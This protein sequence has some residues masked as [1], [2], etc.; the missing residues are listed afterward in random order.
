MQLF[1]QNQPQQEPNFFKLSDKI[2][3]IE[4]KELEKNPE[5]QNFIKNS[6][7]T[8]FE[9]FYKNG[10]KEFFYS[11]PI[12]K[13]KLDLE[14]PGSYEDSPHLFPPLI[15]L[16]INPKNF[17][18]EEI[19]KTLFHEFCHHLI[20]NKQKPLQPHTNIEK[21]LFLDENS[22]RWRSIEEGLANIFARF[23]LKKLSNENSFKSLD[24]DYTQ[25]E[26]N[27]EAS[28]PIEQSI[29]LIFLASLDLKIEDLVNLYLK[30]SSISFMLKEKFC[31]KYQISEEEFF[32]L[33]PDPKPLLNFLLSQNFNINDLEQK[34][35]S[36][37]LK[38]D[39]LNFLINNYKELRDGIN[40]Y[41]NMEKDKQILILKTLYSELQKK[42][43]ED[44]LFYQKQENQSKL[45]EATFLI[46]SLLGLD[47]YIQI[48]QVKV[49][50]LNKITNEEEGIINPNF[51][52]FDQPE[53]FKFLSF[54]IHPSKIEHLK[55]DIDN[56][57]K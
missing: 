45:K 16:K 36:L 25:I 43:Q 3:K 54:I 46:A 51:Y 34:I 41:K 56:L 48:E 32:T 31:Q 49:Y 52:I 30:D 26:K 12:L 37:G 9:F 33:L 14:V 57:F 15:S 24:L 53:E 18:K 23:Y 21:H 13:L 28:Y 17:Q 6:T 4:S 7:A 42:A 19:F 40:K 38:Q 1:N 55:E 10:A 8:I 29:I 44:P 39:Y 5:I 47:D 2:I 27:L 50:L 20:S 11:L 35:Q 22:E